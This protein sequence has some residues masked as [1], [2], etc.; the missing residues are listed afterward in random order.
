MPAWRALLRDGVIESRIV[1]EEFSRIR[2]DDL[3]DWQ[4]LSFAR[5]SPGVTP[6]DFL[7]AIS[8]REDA[9]AEPGATLRR[10]EFLVPVANAYHP[11]PGATANIYSL[12]YIRVFDDQIAAYREMMET[13]TG[14]AVGAMVR[15]GSAHDFLT[16]DTARVLQS[17]EGLPDWNAI[18]VLGLDAA[19]RWD[20]FPQAIDKH[21]RAIDPD[22]GFE[23]VFGP[24]PEMRAMERH[25]FAHRVEA[26]SIGD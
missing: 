8:G 21:L 4:F 14:P 19:E 9:F 22:S 23:A 6:D 15:D 5:L 3:P 24:L 11:Q 25:V 12:E 7:A 10:A 1:F 18:H 20:K 26:L 17:S 16:F 13:Q 2:D